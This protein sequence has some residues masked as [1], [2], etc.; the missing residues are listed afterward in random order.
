MAALLL[1]ATT[2]PEHFRTGWTLG[3]QTCFPRMLEQNTPPLGAEVGKMT[4]GARCIKLETL[5]S[6]GD[7]HMALFR[8]GGSSSQAETPGSN[9][10][11]A[12]EAPPLGNLATDAQVHSAVVS[13]S[14]SSSAIN[15]RSNTDRH[16]DY[17]CARSAAP[18]LTENQDFASLGLM[19]YGTP[20]LVTPGL[21]TQVQLFQQR[22]SLTPFAT[23]NRSI[24]SEK[25]KGSSRTATF[26]STP[27]GAGI[28]TSQRGPTWRS[29]CALPLHWHL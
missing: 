8:D 24:F 19:L 27:D 13:G 2:L 17:P 11:D 23:C 21:S 20:P 3:A 16:G 25:T 10:L 26:S 5:D 9:L 4:A 1:A 22:P 6:C 7:G 18:V 14:T 12:V 29:C 15:A 28:V